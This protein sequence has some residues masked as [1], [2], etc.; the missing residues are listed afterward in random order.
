MDP[1]LVLL[2]APVIA[3]GVGGAVFSHFFDR[4]LGDEDDPGSEEEIAKRKNV[5]LIHQAGEQLER[6]GKLDAST[7][8]ALTRRHRQLRGWEERERQEAETTTSRLENAFVGATLGLALA[9]FLGVGI[10]V[11]MS[12]G[13]WDGR[14]WPLLEDSPLS[15]ADVERRAASTLERD[16]SCGRAEEAQRY[17]CSD[18]SGR[19]WVVRMEDDRRVAIEREDAQ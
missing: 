4:V 16:V 17:V 6:R 15:L 18:G 14:H 7:R 5:R 10:G 2:L 13:L 11:A 1:W 8:R 12:I 3:L 9:A 19:G